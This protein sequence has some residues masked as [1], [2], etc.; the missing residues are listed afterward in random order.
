MKLTDADVQ[1]IIRLLDDSGYDE[2][3]VETERFRLVLRRAGGGW[4]QQRQTLAK[5]KRADPPAAVSEYEDATAHTAP[6]EPAAKPGPD[7]GWIVAPLAGIC[8]RAPRPGD[9]PFVAVGTK[10]QPDTVIAII[11]VMKLMY[12]VTAGVA[13]EIAEICVADG[14][15]V[16]KGQ[17]LMRVRPSARPGKRGRRR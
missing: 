9:A 16:A 7:P 5:A 12:S 3:A 1:E 11:E 10:V 4:T 13:G 15:P 17:C 8:Y 14:T 6:R 2:L